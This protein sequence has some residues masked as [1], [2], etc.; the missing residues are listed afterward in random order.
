MAIDSGERLGCGISIVLVIIT[1]EIITNEYIP[2]CKEFLWIR[3]FI[4][5]ST[6]F[7]FVSLFETIFVSWLY[8]LDKRW[9]ERQ[10]R[11]NLEQS[12]EAESNG[13]NLIAEENSLQSSNDRVFSWIKD[14]NPQLLVRRLDRICLFFFPLAYTITVIAL[15]LQN[16]QMID[17]RDTWLK[18]EPVPQQ[19]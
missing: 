9:K 17:E 10:D 3:N 5:V 12:E 19:L 1:Q 8:Y 4:Q 18:G 15:F 11:I 13:E 16:K 14:I 2:L 6:Y 7:T